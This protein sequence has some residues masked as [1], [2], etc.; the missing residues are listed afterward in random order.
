MERPQDLYSI[1]MKRITLGILVILCC[2]ELSNS[3]VHGQNLVVNPS[4][5]ITATNCGAFGG[6]GFFTDLA[7]SWDNAN[8][9]TPGDSC[10]SPDLFSACNL[11]VTTMPGG[12][13]GFQ[14]SHTGT[15]HAG[16]ITHEPLSQYR[17]YI[18]GRTSSPL[19]AGQT[20]CVS[21]Y[22]SRADATPYAT[23]NIGVRFTNTQYLRNACPGTSN[24]LINLPPQLNTPCVITDTI[25]W[26]RLQWDYVAAGG[27]QYF[28][29]GNFFNNAA[30]TIQTPGTALL[31]PYGYYFIDDVSIVPS[32][33]CYA[34]L[35]GPTTY[36]ISDPVATLSALGG[37]G[38]FC[39]NAVSGTWSGP[40]IVDPIAGAFDP[41]VAGVGNHTITFTMS[42]GYTGSIQLTVGP[43]AGL[44]VCSDGVGGTWTVSNGVGPYTWQNE[45]TVEDCSAC[46]ALCIVPPGCAVNVTQWNTFA[47]GT[48]IPAP[49]TFPIQVIDGSGTIF[50]ISS[51]NGVQ[52]CAACPTITVSIVDQED[53]N[54][55]GSN[56]GSA[57][58]LGTGGTAPY[59]YS[60]SPGALSGA[61]QTTLAAGV[62]TV[63]ATDASNCTGTVQVTIGQAP[64]SVT[65][66]IVS[67]TDASCAGN[68][69]TATAEA[70]GGTA[71]V[72]YSWAPSG[73]I[74]ATATG[75]AA[76][77]YTVT[78]T[79]ADGCTAQATATI[80]SSGGPTISAVDVSPTGCNPPSGTITITAAGTGLEYSIDGGTTF[81]A[82]NSFTGLVTGT[83]DVVVSD[84]DGCTAT[85]T[86]TIT[87]TSGPVLDPVVTTPSD[88]NGSTGS[89][90]LSAPGA[91]LEFSIDGGATF[92]ANGTFTG[93]PPG[94]YD[95]V[96]R[97]ANGCTSTAQASV[98][99]L[100]GPTI[101]QV[102]G[103][104]PSCGSS[105]GNI[106]IVATGTGIEYSIDGGVTFQASNVFPGLTSGSYAIVVSSAGCQLTA[107]VVLNDGTGPVI[108]ALIAF[109]P[110][111]SGDTN[112]TVTVQASGNAPFQF[113]IDGGAT[114]GASPS[115]NGLAPG[116]Y[117]V[118][119]RDPGGCE[120]TQTV[121]LTDPALLEVTVAVT[122]PGCSGAC[123]GT[124]TAT[125]VGGTIGNGYQFT[126]P[127]G[128]G[129][130]TSPEAIGICAGTF[131]MQV[132][133]ANGCTVSADYTLTDALPFTIEGV[134]ATDETCQGVCDGSII[135]QASTGVTYVIGQGIP[136]TSPVFTGLCAGIYTV[137]VADANGCTASVTD[138]VEAGSVIIASFSVTPTVAS[139][140]DP[141]FVFINNSTNAVSYSWDFG[142][143]GTSSEV[144]PSL[145]L[146]ELATEFTACLTATD[147]EGCT[148][149]QCAVLIVRADFAIH[150]PN[151][152]TPDNDG[153]NDMFHAI[154]DPS[155][156]QN[157]RMA[158]YNRWG[159]EIHVS[160]DIL[161][162]WDGS[163]NGTKVQDGVYV[164]RV[165]VQDP[166]TAEIYNFVG[167]VTLLR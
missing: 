147:P 27:E 59:T 156:N 37:V 43:C 102:V 58:V 20:Y 122:D 105:D 70:L 74:A 18:Q 22:V 96:V 98:G 47:T 154:G 71:P 81:Q 107:T 41:S 152:F 12:V 42:C 36:C 45:I 101:D 165:N 52:P 14:Y 146:P 100:T 63:T 76:G 84:A 104:D 67:T 112:G 134:L 167:H 148:D 123:N 23:N 29:I 160:T 6:E 46:L 93:L 33:C 83:Y 57:T 143:Y 34:D 153:I 91:G 51:A 35:D 72:S 128:T 144:D 163:Y 61:T 114:F 138:T 145:T 99:T 136:Q 133:D 64:P 38:S 86:A 68:D 129:G 8:N 161:Q 32:T 21:M 50:V 118:V 155:L 124:A 44:T 90:T 2:I 87:G 103:T 24:S 55:T 26:V 4:F 110:L 106:T 108:D 141:N 73:G 65:V 25:T 62:Y 135:V 66:S 56:T 131:T 78:A 158:I 126:W 157:F 13:L 162:G 60:W 142:P 164:W 75:L 69:G 79:D 120:T 30:T 10:S 116:S 117:D 109:D 7:G 137:T 48:S 127:N 3:S 82:S 16:F 119:V 97:D 92:Q 85:G 95:V 39:S 166:N 150:V 17:E 28:V 53:P 88:C 140:F 54:C 113:S 94:L 139:T 89:M 132:S 11:F 49:S 115:F 9:N 5:E 1:S 130:S 15:R 111:C 125:V 40:G 159:E 31:N 121:A 80:A 77:T 149:T 19:M 151:T